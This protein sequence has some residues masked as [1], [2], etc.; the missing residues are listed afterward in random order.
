[1]F[2]PTIA[3]RRHR[4]VFGA[5]AGFSAAFHSSFALALIYVRLSSLTS[6][7][8]VRLES[9]TYTGLQS[10]LVVAFYHPSVDIWPFVAAARAEMG[11]EQSS[12]IVISSS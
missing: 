3:P 10:W 11:G 9:L 6:A 8:L 5:A 1:L 4:Y 12:R 2:R 7:V